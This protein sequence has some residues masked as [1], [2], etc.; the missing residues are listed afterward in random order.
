MQSR[1]TAQKMKFFVKDFFSNYAVS[2]L[3]QIPDGLETRTSTMKLFIRKKDSIIDIRL[4][5]KYA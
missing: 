5:S 2:I 3:V 4:G 1:R